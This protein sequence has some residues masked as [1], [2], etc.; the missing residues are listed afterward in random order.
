MAP[1]DT[2]PKF[3]TVGLALSELEDEDEGTAAGSAAE[4]LELPFALVTPVHPD[5]I[6]VENSNV[7]DITRVKR[8][9][10]WDASQP[11][12]SR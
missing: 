11:V 9:G 10:V 6:A 2:L 7:T 4:A 1:I 12:K 5:R 8:R 3:S